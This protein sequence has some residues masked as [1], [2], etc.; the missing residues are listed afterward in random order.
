[1]SATG[2]S[3]IVLA[4]GASRRFGSDKLAASLEGRTLLERSIAALAEVTDEVL[5][6]VA[7]GDDRSL[8]ALGVPIRRVVD[9]EAFGGPL[10]G[11][12]AG[13]EEAREPLAL[14]IGGDMPSL[15]PEVL[16]SLV[17]A[18]V[19]GEGSIDAVALEDR[20]TTRPLP[21]AVR[22]GAATEMARRLLA[23]DER[24]LRS[25]LA[26]LRTRA[27]P[28]IEWRALDPEAATLRDVDRPGDL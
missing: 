2:V 12:L 18:L 26:R 4:G 13:L 9:P 22:N 21:L 11:L 16:R 8:P 23:D 27:I 6:V 1:M 14:G 7:P 28:E 15:V 5:V 20:G 24:S 3:G 17:R 10:V 25:L 19:A